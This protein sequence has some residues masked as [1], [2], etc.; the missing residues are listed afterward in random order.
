[1]RVIAKTKF[2]H[3]G[4]GPELLKV[5]FST[6]SAHLVA[7][8][9]S[10]P[11]WDGKAVGIRHLRITKAQVHMFTPEEVEN[12]QASEPD[13]GA[14]DKRGLVSLGRTAWLSSF[15]QRHLDRCEHFRA[16]FYDYM[17]DV[18]CEDVTA[19][20][21]AYVPESEGSGGAA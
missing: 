20:E 21:G 11:D 19:Q 1:V 8:D 17:L 7:I 3:D 13:W 12:Y 6:R 5:H 4:R 10:P 14:T 15:A 9:Y 2:R 16:M 18:I